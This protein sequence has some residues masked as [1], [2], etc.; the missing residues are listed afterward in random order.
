[1]RDLEAESITYLERANPLCGPLVRSAVHSLELPPRSR[2]I[3]IGCGIGLS[4]VALAEEAQPAGVV[5]GVDV[6]DR[7]LEHAR[8][9]LRGLPIAD[10]VSFQPG[11]MNSLRYRNYEFDWACSV[12]CVGYP[13]GDFP[14]ILKEMARV[15]RP[16][17]LIA[18]LA[19]S[20]QQLLPGY[21]MLEARLNADCSAYEPFLRSQPPVSHFHRA[22]HWFPESG[23]S[24]PRFSTF[25][26]SVQAPLSLEMKSAVASLFE[27]LWAGSLSQASE[28]DAELY[29]E[30]CAP[31]SPGC[32]LDAPDY[33]GF[34][35]YSLFSGVVD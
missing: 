14:G 2:G 4:T 12:D 15:V 21:T 8:R 19:W 5:V 10:S 28:R 6:S 20:S 27:M 7:A 25:V 30:L 18:L 9:R 11:D 31:D 26:R 3:D 24:R 32:I 17:G 13:A 35:T 16:G 29:R 34:F 22:L 1:M 33:C 23:I